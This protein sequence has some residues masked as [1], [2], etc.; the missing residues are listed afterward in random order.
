[1]EIDKNKLNV[2]TFYLP[3]YHEIPENNAAFGKGFTEWTNVRKAKPLFEGH[4]QPRVPKDNNY[5]CLL[6]NGKT[7]EEQAK[8]AKAN[9]IT[10]FCY[11]H[12][13]FAHG[14]KLLEKPLEEMLANKKIDIPFCLCWAN[15]NW[16][17]K[18]D[19]G[20]NGVI[21]YQEYDKLEDIEEHVKYIC[22]FMKDDRYMT[23][24]G[25]PIFVLYRPDLIPHLKKYIAEMKRCFAKYGFGNVLF[26]IQQPFYYFEKK[27]LKLF[28]Y[29]IEYE[30][31]YSIIE[32]LHESK[33]LKR[34]IK[35][36]LI[37]LHFKRFL[38]KK[39][40]KNRKLTIRDYDKDWNRI[41]N[42]KINSKQLVSGG[43]IDF[44]NTPR[45]KTGVM[46]KG[47]NPEKFDLYF[48][49]LCEKTLKEYS[50]PI[51]FVM[52]WNEWGEGCYL[53]PDED[54][55]TAYLSSIKKYVTK[56]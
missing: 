49:Q 10:G 14:K 8:L 2:I 50:L 31:S 16:T 42:R 43:F 34:F 25:R 35:K 12:Y 44:D 56:K 3:Q 22:E 39:Q 5:Y 32:E 51:I 9:G 55:D 30:P 13:Y 11:Y 48:G 7:M 26:F 38:D 4:R 24:D 41:L 23:L 15:E 17:N 37:K 19:G 52:A 53:E 40:D 18:W 21:A 6:D 33:S 47:A 27:N 36:I 46:Y 54:Y 20:D 28:D 1:M 45:V 29:Y